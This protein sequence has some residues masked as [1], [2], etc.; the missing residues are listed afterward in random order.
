MTTL[1]AITTVGVH[2]H[3]LAPMIGPHMGTPV[4]VAVATEGRLQVLME[5]IDMIEVADQ[6]GRMIGHHVGRHIDSLH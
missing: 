6:G 2:P 1:L 5:G 3:Q 4:V